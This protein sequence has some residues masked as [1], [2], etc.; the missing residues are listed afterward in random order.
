MGA[1]AELRLAHDACDGADHAIKL[2]HFG[3]ELSLAEWG[4]VVVAGAAIFRRGSPTRLDPSLEQ[5]A[6]ERGIER[7]FLNSENILRDLLDGFG[8]FEAVELA[9]ALERAQNQQIQ[10]AGRNFI[11]RHAVSLEFG[12]LGCVSML[13]LT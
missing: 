2:Q 5:H 3:F 12:A 9:G 11:T 8:D 7:A 4:E 10:S 6:L 13:R 1:A